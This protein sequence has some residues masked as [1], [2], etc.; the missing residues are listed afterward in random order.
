MQSQNGW[1]VIKDPDH[2]RLWRIP[3]TGRHLRLHPHHAGFLLAHFAL[4]FH[5]EIERLDR[6]VWDDWGYAFRP[7]RGQSTGF[8]NHASGTAMDLNAT[9]HPLGKQGTFRRMQATRIRT[10]LAW[11]RGVIRWGGDYNGRKDEMHFEINKGIGAVEWQAKRLSK[12]PRGKRIL[13]E[14]PGYR[15][16]R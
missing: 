9:R 13:R 4:W 14:N 8:S 11:M 6:G 12:T 1:P 10:R 7:I 15:P 16:P 3:G 5:E 2:T